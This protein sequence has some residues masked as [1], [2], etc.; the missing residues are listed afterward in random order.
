[1][2]LIDF[3]KTTITR[4]YSVGKFVTAMHVDI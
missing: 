4:K 3:I 1:M 2:Q